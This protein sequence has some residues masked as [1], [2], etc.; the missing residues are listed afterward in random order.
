[1][2]PEAQ[3]AISAWTKIN[4]SGT[5]VRIS[6]KN[7]VAAGKIQFFHNGREI[8]WIRAVDETDPKLRF[9]NNSYYLFR[10]V[11]L[12]PGKNRFEVYLNGNRVWR[13]TYVPKS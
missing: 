12:S 11:G 3:A 1:V 7:P 13:T 5:A 2:T 6:A 9:A 4:Q 10:T 8:A